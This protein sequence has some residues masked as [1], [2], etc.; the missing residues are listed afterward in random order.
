MP[1]PHPGSVAFYYTL[2]RDKGTGNA[3]AL[4]RGRTPS[5]RDSLVLEY[6]WCLKR[7][8][9]ASLEKGGGSLG[10]GITGARPPGETVW[11]AARFISIVIMLHGTRRVPVI[12]RYV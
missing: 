8:G 10:E 6:S 3:K 1:E 2:S 4:G 7:P 11:I 5:A 12:G 9:Q